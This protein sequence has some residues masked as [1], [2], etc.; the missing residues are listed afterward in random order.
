MS[1]YSD[2]VAVITG[3]AGALG[4]AVVAHFQRGGAKITAIDISTETLDRAFPERAS[5]SDGLY[6]PADLTDRD[7]CQQAAQAIQDRFGRIDILANIAGGFIMGEP[8]HG[9]SDK[10]WN[11]LFDLNVRSVMHM[12]AAT[13]PLMLPNERGKI[14]NI[15]ARAAVKGGRNMGAYCASKSG[16][17]RITES[18]A[19]ELRDKGI[20]VNCIMPGTIDTARN[21]A[22]MPNARHD[23]WVDPADIA[24]VIGFLSSDAA[25][26]VHGAAIAVDGLS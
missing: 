10:T 21:R 20:N 12:A 9:T 17:M 4:R 3:A 1:Q 26:A 5:D 23:K 24:N 2:Q 8:V 13:V 6:L 7:A 18:M 25:S 14:I 22:D 16:V 15:A 11:F 19:A